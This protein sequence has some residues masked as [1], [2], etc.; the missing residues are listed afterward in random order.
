MDQTTMQTDEKLVFVSEP[1]IP[2]HD[3]FYPPFLQNFEFL[4]LGKTKNKV[5]INGHEAMKK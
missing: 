5:K 2:F 3:D 1:I 4:F